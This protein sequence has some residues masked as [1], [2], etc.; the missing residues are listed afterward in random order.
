MVKPTRYREVLTKTSS[1]GIFA[2]LL[3]PSAEAQ[4]VL[5]PVS[6][7]QRAETAEYGLEEII[8]TAQRRAE[9]LQDVPIAVTALTSTALSNAGV[10]ATRDLPQIVP[11]VQM[12]RSGPSGLFFIRGVG[13]TN[14]ASGE[15]GANAVYVDGVYL[16]DLSQTINYFNSVERVEVLKGPQGTL[17]GRN[18]TGGLIHVITREPGSE[19][20]MTGKIGYANYSTVT[21][22]VYAGGPITNDI[23]ADIAVTS[24]HQQDGWGRNLT[25]GIKNKVNDYQGVRSKIVARPLD[26][27]KITLAGD[28]FTSEDNLGLGW[29]LADGTVG[30]GGFVSPG[31]HD[32]T[33]NREALT[34]LELW[35]LSMTGEADL[36]FADLTSITAVRRT[37]NDSKFD[38]DGGPLDLVNIGY[39]AR[40]KTFQQELRLASRQTEPL[41]WQAGVFYLKS[42][43]ST[44]QTQFGTAFAAQSL[45]QVDIKSSLT[46]ESYAAFGEL[47]Y[48]IT[49]TTKVT[50]G[51]R[52]TDEIRQ[53]NGN[54][55]P[56]L[57]NSTILPTASVKS[58]LKY[59]EVT[60]RIALRQEL[61]DNI[62]VYASVNRGFKAGTYSLQSPSSPPVNPQF[63]MAYE[64]GLKSELFDRR[65]R[66]NLAVY[67]YD[68]DDYQVRSAA[69]ATPGA[70]ILLNAATVKVD[71][72]DVEFEGKVT[73]QLR[74]FGGVTALKSRFSKFG[75]PG[76]DFQAPISYP[77]PATCPPGLIGTSDPGV[78][79][80]GPR[81]GGLTTCFGGVSG[82]RTPLAPK[83]SASF[84]ASY[85][86]DISESG[87]L[88]LSALY[89]YNSGYVFEPDNKARQGRFNLLNGSVEY[90]PT[91][92]VGIEFW[93]NNLTNS[94]YVVQGLST[95]TGV[96]EVIAPPRTY[97]VNLKFDF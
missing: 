65:L 43:A 88:R 42:G 54:Q 48:S 90:R 30:T 94:H 66:V 16:G 15:E 95:G 36:G 86:M 28:Y 7:S 41:S 71:G 74:L 67:H 51:I 79:G 37:R 72:V 35:G 26:A 77:N 68:I 89:N 4:E 92:E 52:Y 84:G 34:K 44:D 78:I 25:L 9:S 59:S 24:L 38:V 82:N 49:P 5:P 56:T 18:A 93:A 70:N 14:A 87:S 33:A 19:A 61:S 23:S 8:V 17:F 12:T 40:N 91:Q 85:T 20:T 76:A 11:S 75:G 58:R 60:Y 45:K 10:D 96:T 31:G 73:D 64:A 6:A 1:F 29:R 47:T 81:T 21:A 62:N 50:G 3:V 46:T 39:L 13:T 2:F 63:I 32:T 97:G 22:Q 53:F 55:T 83:L 69:A 27:L 80:A 57:L